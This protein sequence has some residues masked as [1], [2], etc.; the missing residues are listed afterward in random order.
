VKSLR[1]NILSESDKYDKIVRDWLRKKPLYEQQIQTNTDKILTLKQQIEDLIIERIGDREH[2]AVYNSMI[3]KREEEIEFLEKKIA[4]LK[5]Y[6]KVCK[7]QK[8]LLKNTTQILDEILSE[9]TISDV[10]LRMLVK[11]ITIHQ[12]EDKSLDVNFEMNG[13][14]NGSTSV[15]IETDESKT[16]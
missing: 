16:A 7:Q 14:F 1:D 15:F 11:K 13:D 2:A 12:N 10:N 3:A 8:E 9:G 5:E 4:E 6:D